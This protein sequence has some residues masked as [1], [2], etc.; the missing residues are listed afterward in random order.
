MALRL[1]ARFWEGRA[2]RPG[3]GRLVADH[4]PEDAFLAEVEGIKTDLNEAREKIEAPISRLGAVL[5]SSAILFREGLEA[6]L[7]LAALMA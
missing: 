3:L 4:A 7:I 1:E 2:D 5:Q 6:V